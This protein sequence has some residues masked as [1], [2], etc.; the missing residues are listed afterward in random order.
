MIISDGVESVY[1]VRSF[2]VLVT[3][4]LRPVV[5]CG[6]FQYQHAAPRG[7]HVAAV[8]VQRAA[9][10]ISLRGN[11]KQVHRVSVVLQVLILV[12]RM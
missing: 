4:F 9:D 12:C 6:C 5:R 7:S 2:A 11:N 10:C 8:F 1:E 3:G